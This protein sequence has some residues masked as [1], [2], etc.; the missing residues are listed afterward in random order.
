MAADIRA[1]PS[2][3][4]KRQ[5]D[6]TTLTTARDAITKAL[7]HQVITWEQEAADAAAQGDY[8]SAQQFQ[9]WAF[10]A[11]LAIHTASLAAGALILEALDS[12]TLVED[13]R[14]VQLPELHSPTA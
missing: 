10:S 13:L 1:T 12:L 14:T 11:D 5:L 3:T 4:A 2:I 6:L 7:Q 8:R 9:A